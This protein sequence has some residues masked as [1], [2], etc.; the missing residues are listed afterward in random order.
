MSDP[1]PKILAGELLAAE[2]AYHAA[3]HRHQ[4]ERTGASGQLL[5]EAE[6]RLVAFKELVELVSKGKVQH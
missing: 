2:A 3:I 4:T 6:E 5:L 1:D